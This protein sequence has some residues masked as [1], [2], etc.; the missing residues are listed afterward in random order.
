MS[1]ISS[2]PGAP[3][4]S[5]HLQEKL[6]LHV[7]ASSSWGKGGG[8]GIPRGTPPFPEAPLLRWCTP[9]LGSPASPLPTRSHSWL[10][11]IGTQVPEALFRFGNMIPPSLDPL[12]PSPINNSYFPHLGRLEVRRLLTLGIAP[13]F[14]WN[15]PANRP[16]TDSSILPSVIHP[17]VP[18]SVLT[19]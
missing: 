17:S 16:S 7:G 5:L 6:V 1:D 13:L 8:K 14:L 9:S 3:P 19:A 2:H 11:P 4:H 18:P 15:P 12:A 10:H